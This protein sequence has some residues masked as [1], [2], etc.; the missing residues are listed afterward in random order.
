[1]QNRKLEGKR[2]LTGKVI[3]VY[4]PK[5]LFFSVFSAVELLFFELNNSFSWCAENHGLS[6]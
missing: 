6:F 1:M 5:R 3:L 4:L 2:I